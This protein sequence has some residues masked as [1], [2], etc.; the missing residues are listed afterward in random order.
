ME[1]DLELVN[2]HPAGVGSADRRSMRGDGQR[3]R[4]PFPGGSVRSSG[5]LPQRL[6]KGAE[7]PELINYRISTDI[8]A[9]A[10]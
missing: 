3:L 5:A 6:A 2:R 8:A 7:G 4:N 1:G 10:T 9:A